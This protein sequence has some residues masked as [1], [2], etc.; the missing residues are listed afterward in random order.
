MQ[1]NIPKEIAADLSEQE[2]LL[3]LAIGLYVGEHASMG[4]GAE[5]ARIS[6]SEFQLHLGRR[7]ICVNYTEEDFA[8]D[9]LAIEKLAKPR[10]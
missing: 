6:I 3:D 1:I 5:V 2:I 8:S 7:G 4:Q 10:R 9:M